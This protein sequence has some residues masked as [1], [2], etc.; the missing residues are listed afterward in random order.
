MMNGQLYGKPDFY[1]MVKCK[2]GERKMQFMIDESSITEY[3]PISE[4]P[5][6]KK[7]ELV[8]KLYQDKDGLSR[9]EI[10]K[11]KD[12]GYPYVIEYNMVPS[13]WKSIEFLKKCNNLIK[14]IMEKYK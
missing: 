9:K 3:I 13:E 8:L 4:I 14:T 7:Y 1:L 11:L 2:L 6:D 5:E 12:H 10:R